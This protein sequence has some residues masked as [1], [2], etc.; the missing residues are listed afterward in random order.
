M[1]TCDL[2]VMRPEVPICGEFKPLDQNLTTGGFSLLSVGSYGNERPAFAG[3]LTME[4]AGLEPATSWVRFRRN[5]LP[6][7][8]MSCDMPYL[9]GFEASLLRGLLPFFAAAT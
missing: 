6:Y 8:A 7:V 9:C 5:A 2:R 1:R 3:L 4:L